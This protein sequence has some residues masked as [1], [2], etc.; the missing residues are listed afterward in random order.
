[1]A[2]C[3]SVDDEVL[4]GL[5]DI[6]KS[7]CG[8]RD[9]AGRYGGE[10]FCLAVVGY[11]ERDLETLAERRRQAVA[12]VR[13]WLPN[14]EAVTISVGIASLDGATCQMFELMKRADEALYAANNTGRNCVV[15]WKKIPALSQELQQGHSAGRDT[16]QNVAMAQEARLASAVDLHARR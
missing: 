7:S 12:G 1:M 5:A 13:G 3:G 2:D 11:P 9:I 4:V 14:G 15:S 16:R 10:E 6:M 8:A